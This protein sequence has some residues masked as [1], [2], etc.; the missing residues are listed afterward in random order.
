[1]QPNR[2]IY[3]A[4]G[5]LL[6]GAA[7]IAVANSQSDSEIKAGDSS[8]A[9]DVGP[10][11]S[12]GPLVPSELSVTPASFAQDEAPRRLP[13]VSDSDP[14][15]ATKLKELRRIVAEEMPGASD[16]QKDVWTE[17]FADMPE[18]A[19]RLMLQQRRELMGLPAPTPSVIAPRAEVARAQVPASSIDRGV[20]LQAQAIVLRNLV[21]ANTVGYCRTVVEFSGSSPTSSLNIAEIRFDMNS[22][23]PVHTGRSMDLSVVSG[24]FVLEDGDR[25]LFSKVGRFSVGDDGHLVVR[26]DGKQLKLAGL[27]ALP[28][29]TERFVV[30]EAGA[31]S[32]MIGD[33]ETKLGQIRVARFLDASRMVSEDGCLFSPSPASGP[34]VDVATPQVRQGELIPSNVDVRTERQ[35]MELLKQ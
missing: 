6:V 19:V 33:V 28:G 35:M 21:N 25:S 22:K 18:E 30:S 32:A 4:W 7:V 14:L 8:Q 17:E 31:A 29:G 15:A 12:G 20:L 26:V 23:L 2:L 5:L 16:V 11:G 10:P 27:K 9:K 3:G 13:V 1:M 24:F 34:P